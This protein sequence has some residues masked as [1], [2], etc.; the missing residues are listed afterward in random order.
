MDLGMEDECKKNLSDLTDV[1]QSVSA[2]DN[3]VAAEPS[4]KGLAKEHPSAV[5]PSDK[6]QQQDKPSAVLPS[7]WKDLAKA[8]V[9]KAPPIRW[10]GPPIRPGPYARVVSASGPKMAAKKSPSPK[11]MADPR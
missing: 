6:G 3:K 1:L 7:D 11:M 5:L 2:A 8:N 10:K 4:H 9:G